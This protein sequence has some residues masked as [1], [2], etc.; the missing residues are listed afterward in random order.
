MPTKS[1]PYPVLNNGDDIDGKFSFSLS[2]TL[3]PEHVLLDGVFEL[4][5]ETIET[6]IHDDSARYVAEVVCPATFYREVFDFR[7]NAF[8]ATIPAAQLRGQVIVSSS[9]C[10]RKFVGDYEPVG[11]HPDLTGGSSDLA[12]GELLAIG[13][14]AFFNAD[15]EFDPLRAPVSSFMRIQKG[16]SKTGPVTVDYD[17]DKIVIK[18]SHDDHASYGELPRK[19][20]SGILHAS[21][22]L[23][24]LTDTLHIMT[25]SRPVYQ[26]QQW[27]ARIEQICAQRGFDLSEPLETA[28]KLL[29]FPLGRNFRSI[30]ELVEVD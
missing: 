3:E 1:F 13:E 2:Y 28:Q 24:V 12:E 29:A 5:H 9:I 11:I 7:Q 30:K 23:P 4:E 26:D 14:T 20:V 8:S 21:V 10:T 27:F 22:V 19:R 18:L 16:T 6:L 15:K 17:D 25:T